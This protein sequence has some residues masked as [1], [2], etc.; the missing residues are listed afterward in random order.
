MQGGAELCGPGVKGFYFVTLLGL[1]DGPSCNNKDKDD[2]L[3]INI[4]M[5]SI[6]HALLKPNP[7]KYNEYKEMKVLQ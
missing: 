3:T 6:C 2:R 5:V 1:N 4:K 7:S